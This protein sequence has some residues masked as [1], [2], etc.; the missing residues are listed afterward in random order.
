MQRAQGAGALRQQAVHR[1]GEK[2]VHCLDPA[3]RIDHPLLR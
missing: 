3:N 2:I 1:L